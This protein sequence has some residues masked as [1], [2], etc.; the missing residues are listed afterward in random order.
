MKTNIFLDV[1]ECCFQNN[2]VDLKL[3]QTSM[4]TGR[5]DPLHIFEKEKEESSE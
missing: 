4:S 5:F 2:D 1:K 3:D